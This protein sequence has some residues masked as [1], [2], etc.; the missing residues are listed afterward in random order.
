[1]ALFGDLSSSVNISVDSNNQNILDACD[2]VFLTVLPSQASDVL[3]ALEFDPNRH[4][5]V[6]LVVSGVMLRV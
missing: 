1:M 5:L 3:G 6:S 4:V 2:L